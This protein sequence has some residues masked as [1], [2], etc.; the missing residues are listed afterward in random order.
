AKA[1]MRA[2]IIIFDPQNVRATATYPNPK[3]L[4]DGFDIVILNGEVARENG[5][6]DEGLHGEVLQPE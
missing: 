4:A 1:N 6:R 5:R 2:D 3:Q